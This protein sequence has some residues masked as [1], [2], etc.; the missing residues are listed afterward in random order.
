MGLDFVAFAPM[1]TGIGQFLA[2][3]IVWRAAPLTALS[4][5]LNY[6]LPTEYNDPSEVSI[7]CRQRTTGTRIGV[8]RDGGNRCG[9]R[10]VSY[11]L[12]DEDEVGSDQQQQTD[13]MIIKP[14]SSMDIGSPQCNTSI[15]SAISYY[16][17]MDMVT[18]V[19]APLE[20]STF[21]N[22]QGLN[23]FR[24][25]THNIFDYETGSSTQTW[26]QEDDRRLSFADAIEPS[27]QKHEQ[28]IAEV[29]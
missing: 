10:E 24:G 4:F 23:Q 6:T 11:Y 16:P 9:G 20:F 8:C 2:A 17:F 26:R 15:S 18:L 28:M 25:A 7:R 19:V 14:V 1:R 13:P 12:A 22:S 3:W 5:D 29:V 27:L 21:S